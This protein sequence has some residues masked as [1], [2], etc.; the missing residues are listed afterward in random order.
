MRHMGRIF[1][2]FAVLWLASAAAT[3]EQRIA[4]VIGNSAYE[5][6]PLANPVNDAK[7]MSRVLRDH[8]NANVSHG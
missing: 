2:A 1:L 6:G 3:A 8:R 4:L 5:S 7:L